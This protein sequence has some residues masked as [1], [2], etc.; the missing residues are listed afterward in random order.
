LQ[1]STVGTLNRHVKKVHKM[2]AGPEA[3]YRA[4]NQDQ[5]QDADPILYGSLCK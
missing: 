3:A 2:A 5:S 1:F 4:R